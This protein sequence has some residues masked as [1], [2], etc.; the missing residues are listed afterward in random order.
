MCIKTE[1]NK[2]LGVEISHCEIDDI[3]CEEFSSIQMKKL[4]KEWKLALKKNGSSNEKE[5][6]KLI[7]EEVDDNNCEDGD[8]F[9]SSNE[10]TN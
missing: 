1:C 9:I 4:I 3:S 7:H 8:V 6:S 5:A 2:V 10:E